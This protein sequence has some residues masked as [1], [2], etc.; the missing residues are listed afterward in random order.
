M[1][2]E[3]D[4]TTKVIWMCTSGRSAGRTARQLM[5][6]VTSWMGNK[7]SKE[8]NIKVTSPDIQALEKDLAFTKESLEI[9]VRALDWIERSEI[10]EDRIPFPR[11]EEV[12]DRIRRRA[13]EAL[14]AITA[15]G[16]NPLEQPLVT[17]G[18]E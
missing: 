6:I 11:K 4:E 1:G 3:H 9:A 12:L 17:K 15:R 16:D 7:F 18:G 5:E 13:K 10:L 8:L 2:N 14:A